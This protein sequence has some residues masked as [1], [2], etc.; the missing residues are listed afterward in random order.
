[1]ANEFDSHQPDMLFLKELLA[2]AIEKHRSGTLSRILGVAYFREKRVDDAI[3]YLEEAD[4]RR[5]KKVRFAVSILPI[6]MTSRHSAIRFIRQ[7][8]SPCP[9]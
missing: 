4:G 3:R 5:V 2:T 8:I 7:L 6:I 9:T 1:M